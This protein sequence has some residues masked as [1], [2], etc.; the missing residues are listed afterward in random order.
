MGS[1]PKIVVL[2]AGLA[3]IGA[4]TKLL[5]LGFKDVT[6][7]EASGEA[8][9]RVA[10]ASFGKA[11]VD[12]GAQ[13]IH[14]ASEANPV[15]CLLKQ[16]SLL[17]DVVSEEGTDLIF[18]SKGHRVT[19]TSASRIYE[20]GEGI[21][22][23][24]HKGNLGKNMGDHYVERS[25]ALVN[26]WRLS[27]EAKLNALNILT[28][29]GKNTLIDIGAPALNSVALDSWE[30]YTAMG[31][32]LNIEGNMFSVITKLLEDFPKDR[33]LMD[34]PVTQISWD[35]CFCDHE[36]RLYPISIECENGEKI[37]CDHVVVTF[38]LGC[39]KA[40]P[41]TMFDPQLPDYKREAIEKLGFGCINKIFLLYEEAFWERDAESIS[42]V[43]GDE[44]PASLS[45]ASPQWQKNI[46]LFS[47]MRPREKFGDVLIGWCSGSVAQ[48]VESL[49][50]AELS[51]AITCN[52]R[53]FMGDPSIPCPK[54]IM[55]TQWQSK[56]FVRGTYAYV[57]TGVDAAIMDQLA[58]PLSGRKS[59]TE[60]WMT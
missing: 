32:D 46:Q 20:A 11:W 28:L 13:F 15:Y 10:K 56:P 17:T 18:H 37:L 39:L 7:L 53:R 16:H 31:E 23:Q 5:N 51:A 47:V 6:I 44:T 4:A 24:Q 41:A 9:G 8:G 35:G 14:G 30:Y 55:R 29:V 36:N 38:S 58:A 49:P 1:N 50:E 57:P 25:Q 19:A 45:A 60:T 3:G 27:D 40:S 43:W 34:R 21:I 52:F 22:E 54:T 12:T 48:Q 33:L 59:P 42:L 2:G 26:K